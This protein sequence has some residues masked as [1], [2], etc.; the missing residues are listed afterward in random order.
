MPAEDL[1]MRVKEINKEIL[2]HLQKGDIESTLD[3]LRE[4]D[5]CMQ[6][7]LIS[8]EDE[9]IKRDQ[10]LPVLEEIIRQDNEITKLLNQKIDNLK[11]SLTSASTARKLRTNYEKKENR[12]EPRFLDKKG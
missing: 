12:D 7:G 4:R 3:K 9:I 8:L 2:A 10:V 6:G 1:Y 5:E 11:S